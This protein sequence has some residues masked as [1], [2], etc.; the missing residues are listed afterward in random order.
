ME[1]IIHHN[2]ADLYKSLNLPLEQDIDF[3]IHFKPDI[4]NQVPYK[5]PVF[6]ADYFCFNFIKDGSGFYTIDEHTFPFSNR[7]IYFTNPGH[8][9]SYE[10][11]KLKDAYMI[12][13]TENFLRENVHPEVFD[14]FPFLLAEIVSPKVLSEKKFREFETLYKLI[15]DEHEKSSVYKNKIL[16]NLFVALLLKI[17]EEFWLDYNP[18]IEG[19]RNSQIVKSFRRLLESEF[20]KIL[21]KQQNDNKLQA[22]HFAERLNLHPN[23][24][25]SVI[26]SKTGKNPERMD[27]FK[28]PFDR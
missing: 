9:K 7:T 20:R 21:E 17:K 3:T 27:Y 22:Q 19:N 28:D 4:V 12:T 14:E 15:F 25:N 5:S 13:F 23:Y 1:I 2:I 11:N 26:K 8:I 18:I 6:R 16:G 24:L 10:I